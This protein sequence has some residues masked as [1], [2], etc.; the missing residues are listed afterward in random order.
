MGEEVSH[1]LIQG[2]ERLDFFSP[3]PSATGCQSSRSVPSKVNTLQETNISHLGKRK[4]IDS[5]CHGLGDILVPWRVYTCTF[6]NDLTNTDLNDESMVD[7]LDDL[8]IFRV[9]R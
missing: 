1:H 6:Y 7:R 4:I 2:H 8:N 3:L 5:K 9:F